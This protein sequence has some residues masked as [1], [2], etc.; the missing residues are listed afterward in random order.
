MEAM[1]LR[2]VFVASSLLFALVA[3]SIAACDPAEPA[4]VTIANELPAE[5]AEAFTIDKAWYRTTLFVRPVAPGEASESASIGFGKETAY[6][7]LTIGDPPQRYLAMS[8]NEIETSQGE[9]ARIVVN[10]STI[11]STCIGA[12][13]MTEAE[14]KF[15]RERIFPGEEV[16]E[17]GAAC[18]VPPPPG[19]ADGGSEGG[20]TSDAEAGSDAADASGG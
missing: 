5:G 6:F 9:Q 7:V 16:Q 19:A 17:L 2:K 10:A 13:R 11:R 15:I 8:T 4:R 1:F 18:F 20:P 14:Y 3:G 12:P